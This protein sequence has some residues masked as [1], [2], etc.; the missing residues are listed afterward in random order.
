MRVDTVEVYNV[1]V[2][3]AVERSPPR[4][5]GDFTILVSNSTGEQTTWRD[6]AVSSPRQECYSG[7]I[8]GLDRVDDI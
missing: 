3:T 2:D 6:G 5:L 4:E 1:L 8:E 7:S